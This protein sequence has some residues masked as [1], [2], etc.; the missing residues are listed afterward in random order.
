MLVHAVQPVREPAGADFKKGQA[1]L[2]EADRHPL[3]NDAGEMQKDADREGIAVHLGEGPEGA[4][5][6][7]GRRAAIA[8]DRKRHVEPLRFFVERVVHRI[9]ERRRQAHGKKLEAHQAQFS[10]GP[11]ELLGCLLRP[12]ERQYT[13][14]VN[15]VGQ[16]VVFLG[17][18]I[19]GGAASGDTEFGLAELRDVAG[20]GWKKHRLFDVVFVHDLEPRLDLLRRAHV[21]F[22]AGVAEG[23]EKV[24]VEGLIGRPETRVTAVPRR[25]QIFADVALTFQHMSIGVY[26]WRPVSHIFSPPSIAGLIY[27]ADRITTP[28]RVNL[29]ACNQNG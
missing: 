5:A 18:V 24:R 29:F 23:L 2:G 17:E 10:D 15:A 11:A 4:R 7:L 20:A 19:V 22:V 26:Y 13:H 12:L 25:F 14:A 28:E 6:D 16:S 1:E 9:A 8:V 21:A 27:G 3:E